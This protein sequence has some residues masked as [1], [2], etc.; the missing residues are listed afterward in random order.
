MS[1]TELKPLNEMGRDE[2]FDSSSED[3]KRP[4]ESFASPKTYEEACQYF[5]IIITDYIVDGDD[6][7]KNVAT[8]RK[9]DVNVLDDYPITSIT[10]VRGDLPFAE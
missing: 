10:K 2:K 9:K 8:N 3:V 1:K 6:K 7:Q 5:G 4:K